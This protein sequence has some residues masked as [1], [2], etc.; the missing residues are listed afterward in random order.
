M[1]KVRNIDFIQGKRHESFETRINNELGI[2][3]HYFAVTKDCETR[4][5]KPLDFLNL[6]LDA[7]YEAADR[8]KNNKKN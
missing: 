6:I 1:V 2:V 4:E 8:I 7:H 3:E 5:F